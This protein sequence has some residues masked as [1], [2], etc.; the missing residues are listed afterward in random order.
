MYLRTSLLPSGERMHEGGTLVEH[1]SERRRR[2]YHREEEGTDTPPEER[3]V[4]ETSESDE[5]QEAPESHEIRKLRETGESQ[6]TPTPQEYVE[7]H[8]ESVTRKMEAEESKEDRVSE[9]MDRVR[10]ELERPERQAEAIEE[11]LQEVSEALE[12]EEEREQVEVS[13]DASAPE[14]RSVQ[15]TKASE[16]NLQTEV[17]VQ[18]RD[19]EPRT[20]ETAPPEEVH[21]EPEEYYR[22]FG[23]I[24]NRE[25]FDEACERY[26]EL[27]YQKSTSEE[28]AAARSYFDEI[29]REEDSAKPSIIKELEDSEIRRMYETVHDTPPEVKIESMEDVDNLLTVYPQERE[30]SNYEERYRQC[31][32][33]YEVRGDFSIKRDDISEMYGISHGLAGDFRNGIEPTLIKDL[34][35]HEEDKI[36]RE[37]YDSGPEISQKTLEEFRQ[38]EER[39]HLEGG[40]NRSGVHEIDPNIIQEVA[41]YLKEKKRI[42]VHDVTHTLEHMNQDAVT[43]SNRIRY[44]DFREVLDEGRLGDIERV[45][46]TKQHEI[47][48]VLSEKKGLGETRA[49]IAVDDG[50]IY[51]W[52][53]KSRPDELVDAYEKQFYYF[54][55]LRNLTLVVEDLGDRLGI[56]GD[57][58]EVLQHLNEITKQLTHEAHRE[59]ARS[60]PID[61]KSTRLEGKV[62]RVYLDATDSRLSD[63]EGHV[64]KVTGI[65]GQ[66]GIYNPRFPEGQQLEVLKARLA[67][68]I[69]SDCY[70]GESGRITYNEEHRERIDRVQEILQNFGDITLEPKFRRGVY[71]VHIP[72]QIGLTMIHE[73]M[74]PGSKTIQNPGLP[75]G[76]LDWSIEAKRGYLEELIPEDGNFS[77]HRGFSWVRNNALYDGDEGGKHEFKSVISGSEIKLIINEGNTTKGLVPQSELAYGKLVNLS[78]DS[79][80]SKSTEAKRII[81]AI[82]EHPNNLIED[83][84]KLAESLGIQITLRPTAVKYYPR[85]DRVSVKYTATTTSKNDAVEWGISCPPNDVQKREEV[86]KWLRAVAEAWLENREWE[87][88]A[89]T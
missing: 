88:W 30:H 10:A 39:F 32:V 78:S 20:E 5:P 75:E 37:W 12:D 60:R 11:R 34:R 56:E 9:G 58:R 33:Y 74:T 35:K 59:V 27:E 21:N 23:E 64:T 46:R 67:A 22:R 6:E 24:Q 49:K 68:I 15:E 26:P 45:I 84:T 51:T 87:E 81:Q 18:E 73:G 55:N 80:M 77:T 16:E 29:D 25:E 28:V 31:E 14:V 71:D 3:E 50:K 47:E 19:A 4:R 48:K 1:T 63:L 7:E 70:L 83:E 40:E 72:N 38:R 82:S 62:I 85:S 53:P 42:T 54:K 2:E 44:A 79:D 17:E 65:N 89:N 61:E 41:D 43:D 13:E 8:M 76:Y 52:I 69:A 66:A 86:E 57:K 36:I